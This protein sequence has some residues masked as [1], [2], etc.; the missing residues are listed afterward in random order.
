MRLMGSGTVLDIIGAFTA[1]QG[2]EHV[3]MRSP[4]TQTAK[5]VHERTDE[6]IKAAKA[7]AARATR[8]EFE[9][10]SARVGNIG[11][12]AGAKRRLHAKTRDPAWR[13]TARGSLPICV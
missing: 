3:G 6:Q 2:L 4:G 8:A 10:T 13:L 12:S 9:S 7:E 1:P 11:N 5:S